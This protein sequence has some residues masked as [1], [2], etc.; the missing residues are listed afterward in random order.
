MRNR[1]IPW[2]K[3][4]Y[5][6]GKYIFWSDL[7]SSH[8]A[9]PVLKLLADQVL[10]SRAKYVANKFDKS[11]FEGLMDEV[12]ANVRKAAEQCVLSVIK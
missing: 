12:A 7:A 3:K 8:Y 4:H 11:Y 5:P 10:T 6:D 2:I 9:N 1:L